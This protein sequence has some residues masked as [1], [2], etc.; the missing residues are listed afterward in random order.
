M[1]C[2]R[3]LFFLFFLSQS[4]YA[5]TLANLKTEVRRNLRDTD[6]II[7]RYTDAVLLDYIN[8]AQKEVVNATWLAEKTT[9]YQLTAL[10]TY[11]VLPQDFLAPKQVYFRSGIQTP[12]VLQ[13]DSQRGLYGKYP[14]WER[15]TTGSTPVEYWISNA[16]SPSQSGVS[17]LNISYI[18]IPTNTSTGTV[19][20][21][22][23]NL[24][25]DLSADTDIPF[26]NRRFLYPYHMA[27][28]YHATYRIK[29]TERKDDE[30]QL[31]FQMF[32]TYI[33]EI[34]NRLGLMP[35]Y[36]PGVSTRP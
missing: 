3:I 31:Y 16:T 13:Q 15:L 36:S 29:L 1:K 18:P 24:V 22:Y 27:L 19:T 11:Y 25:A 12:I 4:V 23:Y 32:K 8:E 20:V 17:P 28:A 30:A 35:D 2:Q 21:W 14:N 10:T 26:E 7:Q 5:L 9:S 6:P 33:D 34:K